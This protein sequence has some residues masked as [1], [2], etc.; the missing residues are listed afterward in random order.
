M[1]IGQD[2]VAERKAPRRQRQRRGRYRRPELI[3]R[4][5]VDRLNY[6]LQ[7][8]SVLYRHYREFGLNEEK[9]WQSAVADFSLDYGREVEALRRERRLAQQ[10]RE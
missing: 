10:D 3:A 8:A 5:A 2:E 9:A 4:G 7:A 6:V 1:F